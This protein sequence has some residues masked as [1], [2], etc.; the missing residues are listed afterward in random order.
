M[1]RAVILLV[2]L[3]AGILSVVPAHAQFN[4]SNLLGDFGVGSGTQPGPGLYAAT[5]YYRYYSD[6][7]KDSSGKRITYSPDAPS[8]ATINAIAPM[9]W[10]VSKVK[11]LGA[12][13]GF[14]ATVPLLDNALQA[15]VFNF[16][17]KTGVHLGD[18]YIRPLDL[19]WH[20]PRADYVTGF[21]LF[22]PTGKFKWGD[23]SNTGLG[24]WSYEV[25][26]GTTVH[27][28]SKK[29]LNFATTAFWETHSKKRDTNIKV[30]QVLTLEGGLGKSYLN[31][32]LT[33]GAAYYAQWKLTSDTPSLYPLDNGGTLDLSQMKH[34]VFGLGPDVTVPLA[35]KTKLFGFLNVRYFWEMGARTKSQGQGLVLTATFPIPSIKIK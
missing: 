14:I 1:K 31:N 26:G 8:S 24:M 32:S 2:W 29:S 25:F 19:G 11:I 15:P 6:T 18:M 33:F 4:G 9:V 27:L 3:A 35:S 13:Y 20:T 7:I 23:T 16:D 12:N 34:R 5:F 10:Y 21:S 17:Q 30:G 22:A 28:D